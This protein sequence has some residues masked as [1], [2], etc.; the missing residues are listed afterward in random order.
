MVTLFKPI[1]CWFENIRTQSNFELVGTCLKTIALTSQLFSI[2]SKME[3]RYVVSLQIKL[4]CLQNLV[5][6]EA[7][8]KEGLDFAWHLFGVREILPHQETILR[9]FFQ[10]RHVYFSA[11]RVSTK[12]GLHHLAYHLAYLWPT[13]GLPLAHC[14][15]TFGLL[16]A[17]LWLTLGLPL[18]HSW[19]TFSS[20]LAYLWP[21][22]GLPS[23]HMAYL[24]PT[25]N[26]NTKRKHK[27]KTQSEN[28]KRKHKTKTQNENTNR[29]H[30]MKHKTK[31]QSE[32][33]K[34]KH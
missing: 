33:T 16:L 19:L 13:V 5:W 17:Y 29:K 28:T 18:A 30:N 21:I 11:P 8:F 20:L 12:R 31:T 7:A 10:G 6:K 1:N 26:E 14:W 34:R 9:K 3:E 24:W 2:K 23:L 25:E 27:T 15:L 22:A 4:S 32:N